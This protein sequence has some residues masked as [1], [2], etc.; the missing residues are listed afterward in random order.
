MSTDMSANLLS[1]GVK[2]SEKNNIN[3]NINPS[4]NIA[5]FVGEFEKEQIKKPVFI[6]DILQFKLILHFITGIL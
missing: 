3:Y 5:I 1:P 4:N 2:T 6:T